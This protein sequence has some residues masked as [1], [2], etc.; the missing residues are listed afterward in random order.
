MPSAIEAQTAASAASSEADGAEAFIGWT[1]SAVVGHA[2]RRR[3]VASRSRRRVPR[4][5]RRPRRS[6]VRAASPAAR[7]AA[8]ASPALSGVVA[9]TPECIFTPVGIPRTGTR[10]AD[11][12][13]EIA[14]RAVASGEQDQVDAAARRARGRRHGCRRPSSGRCARGCG[15]TSTGSECAACDVRAELAGCRHDRDVGRPA[16]EPR[17]RPIGPLCGVRHGSEAACARLAG[18][19]RRFPSARPHHRDPRPG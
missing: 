16:L 19:R 8:A 4:R 10:V 13:V 3:R 7:K 14:R 6:R 1:R 18:R 12:V 17:E 9:N 5:G 2:K 11:G 15:S